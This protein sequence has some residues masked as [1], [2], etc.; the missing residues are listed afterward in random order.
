MDV[1]QSY[2]NIMARVMAYHESMEARLAATARSLEALK[3]VVD[4]TELAAQGVRELKDAV[5]KSVNREIATSTSFRKLIAAS[6]VNSRNVNN[7]Y[8][9]LVEDARTEAQE[10]QRR[11]VELVEVYLRVNAELGPFDRMSALNKLDREFRALFRRPF[12]ND[13]TTMA[14]C[15]KSSTKPMAKECAFGLKPVT[16]PRLRPAVLAAIAEESIHEKAFEQ[17]LFRKDSGLA[18][19]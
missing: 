18:L 2:S 11:K 13:A 19:R 8:L 7:D 10:I 14:I 12:S 1:K 6:R 9:R 15:N 5:Y 16:S 3:S 17:H 4:E